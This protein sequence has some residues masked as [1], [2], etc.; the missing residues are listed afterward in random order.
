MIPKNLVPI[1]RLA[2][3]LARL[4][5]GPVPTYRRLWTLACDGAL[6]TVVIN[7]RHYADPS[8]S[9]VELGLIEADPKKKRTTIAA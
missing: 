7:T 9:A 6:S 2:G 5:N 1:S 3:E 8:V 4:T